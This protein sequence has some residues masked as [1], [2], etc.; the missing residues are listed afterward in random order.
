MSWPSVPAAPLENVYCKHRSAWGLASVPFVLLDEQPESPLGLLA[1][2][3]HP[4]A[5]PKAHPPELAPVIFV[6]V[7]EDGHVRSLAGVRDA[8]KFERAL[9]F[10]VDGRVK[11]L[12]I[13]DEDDRH[14]VRAPVRVGRREPGY[15]RG[16][17][18]LPHRFRLHADRLWLVQL[19]RFRRH[20]EIVA[21][22]ALDL[23][24]PPGDRRPAPFGQER[25]VMPL[26]FCKLAYFLREFQRLRKI[27]D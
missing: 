6:V 15:L 4:R 18:P 14:E 25:G 13:E 10:R 17:H 12:A 27:V 16:P 21:M 2:I 7:D 26:F 3:E 24:R 9:R 19:V 22:Q 23:V 8:A 11:R 20:D 1:R 5:S